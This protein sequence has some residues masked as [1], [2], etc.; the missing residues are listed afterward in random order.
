LSL[1]GEGGVID[2]SVY[3]IILSR[4]LYFGGEMFVSGCPAIDVV[5]GLLFAYG[6]GE[7]FAI[8]VG[9]VCDFFVS[10]QIE[11]AVLETDK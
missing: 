2:G 11:Q 5:D 9:Q 3:E 6:F 1:D 4:L 8:H 10:L 7:L